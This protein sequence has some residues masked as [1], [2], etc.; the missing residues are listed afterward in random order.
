[1]SDDQN[2]SH[3]KLGWGDKSLALKGSMVII[4][5]LLVALGGV[6]V[7]F[8]DVQ[9]KGHDVLADR[10]EMQTC[11]LSLTP[12]ERVQLRTALS[13]GDVRKIETTAFYIRAWCPWIGR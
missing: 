5:V 2:G 10:I 7:Y 8:Q 12:E 9:S 4:V 3:L 11:V 1:M 13:H 6:F